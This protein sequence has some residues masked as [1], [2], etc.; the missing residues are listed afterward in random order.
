MNPL[1]LARQ[2][3]IFS[4]DMSQLG[5]DDTRLSRA[6]KRGTLVRLKQGVYLDRIVWEPLG[7]AD[8]HRLLATIAERLAGPGLVFSHHTAAALLGL[9][10]LG[11]WPD[12]AHVLQ[13]CA[14][15]GRSTTVLICHTVGLRGTP[16]TTI[17][18]L[19]MTSPERTVIDM[20][21]TL[22][23]DVAVI[24]TDA[25]LHADRHTRRCLTTIAD[26]RALVELMSPFRGLRRVLAVLDASTPLS[27]SV[28]ESLC[29]III[30]ELGFADPELQSEFR[31]AEGL[32]G[33]ADFTWLLGKVILEFD[34]KI[35][36]TDA[37]YRNGL[38]ADQI[39][40]LEKLREDRLRALGY[41]VVRATWEL[42]I[43]P[44]RLYRLLR[45]AG[46][47]PVRPA[48]AIHRDWL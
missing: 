26:V 3:L 44:T 40:V 1:E 25:A 41:Q 43:D 19:S 15:G 30:A 8:R 45:N 18:T 48:R 47:V 21:A 9:P 28:G 35:K 39:V 34:G 2:S 24:A 23:F 38:S 32:I 37:R 22:P 36:Y 20:A 17:D 14:A 31:D 13:D 46:L 5:R 12:R 7:S 33:F 16:V 27:E 10:V 11:R 42:L 29:R 6:V 4:C